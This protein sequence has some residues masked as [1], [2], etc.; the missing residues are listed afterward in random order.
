MAAGHL[1]LLLIQCQVPTSAPSDTRSVAAPRV[2]LSV[3][4]KARESI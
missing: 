2:R 3:P 1:K 4:E